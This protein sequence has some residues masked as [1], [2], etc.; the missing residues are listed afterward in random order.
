MVM[1]Y[2]NFLSRTPREEV[3]EPNDNGRHYVHSVFPMP[4]W[5]EEEGLCRSQLLAPS[6]VIAYNTFMNGVDK[7]DQHRSTN[8]TMRKESRVTMSTFTFL[9][10]GATINIYAVMRAITAQDTK[11]IHFQKFHFILIRQLV[12]T[13]TE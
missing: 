11:V 5:L 4:R 2:T 7:F 9:M 3:T 8:P 12:F 13:Y 6:V 10:E 1:F